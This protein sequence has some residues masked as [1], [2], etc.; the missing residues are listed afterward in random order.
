[1][2]FGIVPINVDVFAE[3]D[4]LVPF[5]QRAEALGYESVWT[6]EHVI[7][8]KQYS[9]VY[10]YNPSGKV[11]F[12]PD[13]AIIDPLI[14]LT[15]VAASTK[16]L[17]LGT[18]VNIL[19]QMSPLYL[20]K[21]ASS[22]DYLSQGRLMLGVGVGWLKEEFEAI[23]VPFA[24]RGKR[25]DEYLQALKQVWTGEEVNYHGEF[26]NWQGFMMR[27]RPAQPGGI[28]L[29]IGGVTPAAIRRLVRYGDGWYVIGKDLDDYRAHMRAFHDECQRQGRNPSEIE[30][31]AYWNY[32][33]EGRESLAVY[34]ELG[35]H[36]LLVNMRA[37][38]DRDVTTAMERF[39]EEVVTKYS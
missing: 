39:G 12:R 27:P 28:P 13:A 25:A 23:G 37:L 24:H 32:Y 17:R 14:A 16:R 7:I 4:M 6:A 38:R 26:L 21:W 22:I 10:P 9:S 15:Y 18:G 35:V 20:A 30:I 8:P 34:K 3:P 19:P 2:K 36:R 33:V 5:V 11:P 31:T 29:V 1:M